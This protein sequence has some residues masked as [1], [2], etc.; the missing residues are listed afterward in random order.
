MAPGTEDD[1]L[2]L[3]F[4]NQ[5]ATHAAIQMRLKAAQT[6]TARALRSFRLPVDGTS[7]LSDPN[8]ITALLNEMGGRANMKN[9]AAAYKQL[10]LDQQ[11]RFTEMAGTTTQQ[12]GKIWKEMYLSSLMPP[13][14][15][16]CLATWC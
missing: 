9:L 8:Q 14:S 12:L 11:A 4:R 15:V 13:P 2:L 1:N 7:G 6:E 5:L 16:P 3:Q 10:T